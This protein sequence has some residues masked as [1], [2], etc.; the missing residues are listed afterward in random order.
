[1]CVQVVSFFTGNSFNIKEFEEEVTKVTSK[2]KSAFASGH[3]CT[4]DNK[5]V[6]MFF[7]IQSI[8]ETNST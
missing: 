5:K 8:W 3:D 4:N 2:K 7:K 1:M 6:T